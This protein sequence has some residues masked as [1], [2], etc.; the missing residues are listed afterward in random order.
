MTRTKSIL[1][2]CPFFLIAVILGTACVAQAE[3]IRLKSGE[4]IEGAIVARD[5]DAVKID[6]GLG[7]PLTYYWDEIERIGGEPLSAAPVSPPP[8][9]PEPGPE[10]VTE[11]EAVSNGMQKPDPLDTAPPIPTKQPPPAPPTTNTT[12]PVALRQTQRPVPSSSSAEMS[13]YAQSSSAQPILRHRTDKE[14][15]LK[16]QFERSRA[17]QRQRIETIVQSVGEPF[18]EA[19]EQF[20][21]SR[22][23]LKKLVSQKGKE[24]AIA[25]LLVVYVLMCLPLMLVARRLE[26]PALMAWIP[27]FQLFL[28]LRMAD[29]PLWW[30][31]FFFIPLVNI[32]IYGMLWM[33][34]ARR[35]QQPALLG[36]IMLIPVVKYLLLWYFALFPLRVSL[37]EEPVIQKGIQFK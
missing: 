27:V 21:E 30:F 35:L 14:E 7:I 24:F 20:L 5:N 23:T 18:A 1:R 25:V 8:A 9:E 13:L 32:L 3:V 12:M 28:V 33:T 6:P 11:P 36:V 15:Y 22:P 10:S 2:N 29:R 31:I 16:E 37:A 34:I 4:V 17:I 26:C 19:W